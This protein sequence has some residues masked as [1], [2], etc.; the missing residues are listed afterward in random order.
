MKKKDLLNIT[1]PDVPEELIET[2]QSDK[3]ANNEFVLWN[4][5]ITIEKSYKT[6]LY[7]GAS[8]EDGILVIRMW[9]RILLANRVNNPLS[10]TYIDV[11]AEK[12]I[13]T[14]DGKWTE[15]LLENI[16]A[17]Y[18]HQPKTFW[19]AKDVSTQEDTDLCN[20][21]LGTDENS[22]Y[23]AVREWQDEVRAKANKKKAE[24]RKA[25]WDRMMDLIP[26]KPADFEQWAEGEGTIDDNFLFFKREGKI[27][28]VYC[29][30]CGA[31]Y[32]TT[33]K[34][35]HNPGRKTHWGY[36]RKHRGFCRECHN[37]FDTKSW[38]KQNELRTSSWVVLPQVSG[39]YIS[40]RSFEV[41]KK[42]RKKAEFGEEEK[43]EEKTAIREDSRIF[44]DPQSFESVD[45][46]RWEIAYS[47]SSTEAC[48]RRVRGTD[49]SRSRYPY[50]IQF[51]NMY[52]RNAEEICR[53]AGMQKFLYEKCQGSQHDS[54]QRMLI[55]I[56]KKK[57]IEYLYKA[58]LNRV[59]EAAISKSWMKC[60][61]LKED[62]RNL[63]ELLGI[64]GQ[65]LRTMKDID[66]HYEMIETLREIARRK[67]KVDIETL[68]AMNESEVFIGHLLTEKTGM[69]VQR[70]K[71]KK[72][73]QA[74]RE[75]KSLP[76][77]LAEYRDYLS[78]AERL[79]Y[80]TKDEIICRTP[81]LKRMHDRYSEHYNQHKDQ[82]EERNA[83]KKYAGIKEGSEKNIKHFHY[84]KEGLLIL[85][86][87]SASDIIREGREQHHCVGASNLYMERMQKG[88]SYILFLRKKEEPEKPY[89]T[90]E[91]TWDGHVRQSYGAFN[92]KPDQEK[93][94]G[95]LRYFSRAVKKRKEKEEAEQRVL[96]AAV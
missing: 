31:T 29:T 49:Y 60:M 25:D 92:R 80:D 90:L 70:T 91:V 7:F 51:G 5:E 33:E 86:P 72:K 54:P 94:D 93:I 1:L 16:K 53:A 73:K 45:S 52:M 76:G 87:G 24:R 84:E 65:M 19:G 58:G 69:T 74:A 42:F 17:T 89:Y 15:A 22:V 81:D 50:Q 6:R 12:W 9:P 4:S 26:E 78:I 30:Y 32:K 28:E 63:K 96:V 88:E 44:A 71:K 40:M 77:I 14:T 11:K 95:W 59:A 36:E 20:R 23:E 85:V 43:W 56:A 79:G 61:K 10:I 21:M 27:S 37:F 83:D 47:I 3:Y 68:K 41:V 75:N 2:A 39:E 55:E 46:F 34:M 35:V 13:S 8:E 67:E 82:I 18:A 38:R 57:Y 66:G 64:D 62:A 48:W